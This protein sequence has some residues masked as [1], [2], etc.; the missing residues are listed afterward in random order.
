MTTLYRRHVGGIGTWSIRA[1]ETGLAISHATVI[2]GSE[3]VHNELVE[4]GKQGRS[5]DQQIQSRI[6]SRISRMKDRGYK[7]TIEEA[8]NGNTNQ[9]GLLSP[10]LA[11]PYD[12]VKSINF[13]DA[14][15]QKKLNGHR[16]LITCQD[17]KIIAYSR[18]GKEI[19][20]ITHIT[21][22]LIGHLPE[23]VTIDGELYV[24]GQKLQTIASWVKRKQTATAL[25]MFV[26]Y[27]IVS[28][29]SYKYRHI[30]LSSLL[31]DVQSKRVIVLPHEPFTN[32]EDLIA[33]RDEVIKNGF[34]GLMLRIHGCGY[35][36]GVRSASLIKVKK[37]TDAEFEVIDVVPS[38]DGWGICVCK[39]E[40]DKTFRVSAPGDVREKTEV[41]RRK[42]EFIGRMLT[43]EFAELTQ[44][45]IPFHCSATGW[46]EDI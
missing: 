14:V 10:M 27:D 7:D 12:K 4:S 1:T 42:G 18:K 29:D 15:I 5:L 35:Q 26:A 6:D 17:G 46:R 24:H 45:G 31:A 36:D 16:C 40:N 37:F 9:L 30:E 22:S 25:V 3:V 34:E 44:D 28:S 39:L 41:L 11:Q 43:V 20:A 13:Q 23:G 19:P 33:R 21:D 8:M 2:G 38:S 32:H